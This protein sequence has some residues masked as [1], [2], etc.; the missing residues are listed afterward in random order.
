MAAL[1]NQ[2]FKECINLGKQKEDEVT[3][4][5]LDKIFIKLREELCEY[6]ECKLFV[7]NSLDLLLRSILSERSKLSGTSLNLLKKLFE[8]LKHEMTNIT[9][10][11]SV[12]LKLSGR[13]NKVVYTRA[14]DTLVYICQYIDLI[15]YQKILIE[16]YN[17]TNKN[18]RLGTIKMI[19]ESNS[20][21][22]KLSNLIEKAKTDPSVEIRSICKNNKK[23][24]Q[25]KESGQ[26]DKKEVSVQKT[27]NLYFNHEPKHSPYKKIPKLEPIKEINPC[28]KIRELEKQVRLITNLKKMEKKSKS[29]EFR[30]K[31]N[32][33]TK[34]EPQDDLTPKKLDKYLSKYRTIYGSVLE[35]KAVI[36][37][38]ENAKID[39]SDLNKDVEN[40]S[41]VEE[42]CVEALNHDYT[43]IN[44][45]KTLLPEENVN[46][47]IN[48]SKI[49][50]M[51]EGDKINTKVNLENNDIISSVESKKCEI[52]ES[53]SEINK[54]QCNDT[55]QQKLTDKYNDCQEKQ[56]E[57]ESKQNMLTDFDMSN[58]IEVDLM[59]DSKN[60]FEVLQE[61]L[62]KNTDVLSIEENFSITKNEMPE[63]EQQ[64]SEKTN[65]L[66]DDT[67]KAS[68]SKDIPL[69]NTSTQEQNSE[70]SSKQLL[71]TNNIYK[72]QD[73]NLRGLEHNRFSSLLFADKEEC[74]IYDIN[75]ESPLFKSSKTCIPP[76]CPNVS[77]NLTS[78]SPKTV[79]NTSVS[80]SFLYANDS[81]DVNNTV[82]YTKV[83]SVIYID[84]NSFVPKK[85]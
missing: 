14:H 68:V 40:L 77:E 83:D 35:E 21:S 47:V 19:L 48:D 29:I 16:H 42:S 67:N 8:I 69:I 55:I 39:L 41:L 28:N 18:I 11:L 25:N 79:V 78:N 17:S 84:K 76:D 49:D 56:K 5:K 62:L 30:P 15:Q 37:V 7:D 27:E 64:I 36:D 1:N 71:D 80:S 51:K 75:A 54:I 38:E 26:S 3:W 12:L 81:V 85:E 44:S 43:I 61:G 73:H 4:S 53:N 65:V 82:D 2:L 63:G 46:Y 6:D 31:I 34:K 9:N 52:L 33:I 20:I 66:L 74:V 57:I 10:I 32:F 59:F 72:K 60:K 22:E 70:C 45:E 50:Q 58:K 23:T 13:T 24:V